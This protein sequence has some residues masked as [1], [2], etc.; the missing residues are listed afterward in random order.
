MQQSGSLDALRLPGVYLIITLVA[1]LA[2]ELGFRLA[3]NRL[4]LS[5]P[6]NEA[7]AGHPSAYE[8]REYGCL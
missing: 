8:L 7:P 4:L 1:L 6:E 5:L 2:V 3:R